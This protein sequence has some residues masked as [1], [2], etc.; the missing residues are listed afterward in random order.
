VKLGIGD[1][2][3]LVAVAQGMAVALTTD[4]SIE[5]VHFSAKLHPPQSVGH[6][7]LARSL[8]DI[9]AVGGIPKFALISLAISNR[10]T[11]AWIEAFYGGL[12]GLAKRF[13]G[14]VIGGDTAVVSGPTTVDVI[15]AGVVEPARAL[16]R[17]GARPGDGIYVSG[18]LGLSALGLQ[19]L[20]SG[21]RSKGPRTSPA[22]H[23]HLYPEPRCMLGRFLSQRR[24]ASALI[25]ISDGLST[26]LAHLCEASQ[27]GARIWADRIPK[28]SPLNG[29]RLDREAQLN[30]ALHGGEDYQLLFTVSP[31][32][33]WE[34]PGR[35]QGVHLHCIGQILGSRK[36]LL[37]DRRGKQV[38]LRPGG[39]DH[40]RKA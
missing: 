5:S 19:M 29:P 23:A 3:A 24:L 25:D 1:D 33:S 13:G 37:V 22:V 30:L 9:A 20:K 14:A 18:P 17:S 10:T 31:R 8:S 2:T 15:V 38:V 7:A 26:D 36:V 21:A 4:F 28:Q 27:V 39:Y 12:I 16:R 11:R 34:I 6:R 32:K 35:F 40:F